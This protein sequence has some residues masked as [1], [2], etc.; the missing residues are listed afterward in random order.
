M[1]QE[2]SALPRLSQTPAYVLY[3]YPGGKTASI[4]AR[5]KQV[6]PAALMKQTLIQPSRRAEAQHPHP[7]LFFHSTEAA[8]ISGRSAE[9]SVGYLNL[10]S[11]PVQIRSGRC[12]LQMWAVDLAAGLR[13]TRPVAQGLELAAAFPG[14]TE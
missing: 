14:L 8:P 6:E 11:L 10:F 9:S 13:E 7:E 3:R 2:L 12:C 5:N 4:N 1:Q